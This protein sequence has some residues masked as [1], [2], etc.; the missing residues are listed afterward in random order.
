MD[1]NLLSTNIVTEIREKLLSK[2]NKLILK[3]AELF[4]H[5]N[6]YSVNQLSKLIEEINEQLVVTV[7]QTNI[8]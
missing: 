7:N 3:R 1:I 6:L 5:M 8:L 2:I 4:A